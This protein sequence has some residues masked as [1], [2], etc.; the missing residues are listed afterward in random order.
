MKEEVKICDFQPAKRFEGE[1]RDKEDFLNKNVILWKWE[2]RNSTLSEDTKYVLAEIEHDS[3]KYV[4]TL[5]QVCATRL[6]NATAPIRVKL[7]KRKS[8]RT[9]RVYWDFEAPE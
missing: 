4:I 2:I 9:G 1:R 3:K 6:E 7:I 8:Q 5:P